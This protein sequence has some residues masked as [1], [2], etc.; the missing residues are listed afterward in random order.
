MDNSLVCYLE[1]VELISFVPSPE[2]NIKPDSTNLS[3][4]KLLNKSELTK[5]AWAS[6]TAWYHVFVLS[7]DSTDI[8]SNAVRISWAMLLYDQTVAKR[9]VICETSRAGINTKDSKSVHSLTS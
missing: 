8:M 7:S 9:K 3:L 1:G 5:Q 2:G 4:A 6:A